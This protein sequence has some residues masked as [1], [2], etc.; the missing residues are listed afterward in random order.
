MRATQFKPHYRSNFF[1]SNTVQTG[2]T[3]G[4]S[5]PITAFPELGATTTVPFW[6]VAGGAIDIDRNTSLPLFSGDITLRGGK[7][8]ITLC[9]AD[10]TT[11]V[12]AASVYLCFIRQ[13]TRDPATLATSSRPYGWDPEV[14]PDMATSGTKVLRRWTAFLKYPNPVLT[15]EH[16]VRPRKID[17]AWYLTNATA[18][19]STPSGQFAFL[20]HICNLT[21]TTDTAVALGRYH[22]LSFSADADT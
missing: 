22:N 5:P 8:G 15:C 14:E 9:V 18:P 19:A 11:D 16:K 4:F 17:R 2:G 13:G 6:T 12:I 10:A 7:I 3:L 1:V 20:V 21:S